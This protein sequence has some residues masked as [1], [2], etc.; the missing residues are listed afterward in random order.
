MLGYFSNL[1]KQMWFLHFADFLHFATSNAT[2]RIVIIF[3][4]IADQL[5]GDT[6]VYSE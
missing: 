1:P 6:Q 3:E 5:N 4:T 2:E